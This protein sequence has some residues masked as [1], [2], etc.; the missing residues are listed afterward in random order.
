MQDKVMALDVLA[1]TK[2]GLSIYASAIGESVNL[3]VRE[4]LQ[5][6]RDQS[7]RFQF[8]LYKIAAAKGFYP[9]AKESS[10]QEISSVKAQLSG[11]AAQQQGAGPV[12]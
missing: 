8:D 1:G 11:A 4:T 9:E 10:P 5:K 6:M 12:L 2:A 7:E 3:P